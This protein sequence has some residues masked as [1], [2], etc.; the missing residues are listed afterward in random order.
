MSILEKEAKAL[1]KRGIYK[2]EKSLFEDALRSL[3][4]SKPGLKVEAAIELYK[5]KEISLI[6]AA[7]IASLDIESFKEELSRR[8]LK[9]EVEPPPKAI[10]DRGVSVLMKD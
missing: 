10:L 8:G 9:I 2:D 7:E 4:I 5:A 3:L 1:I 6:K